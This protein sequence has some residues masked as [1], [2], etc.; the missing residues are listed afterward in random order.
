MRLEVIDKITTDIGRGYDGYISLCGFGEPTLHPYINEISEL[1]SAK[2]PDAHIILITDADDDITI[3]SLPY[4]KN[5]EIYCSM[6]EPFS[7]SKIDR[8]NKSPNRIVYRDIHNDNM[9]F[10]NNRAGNSIRQNEKMLPLK[11]PCYLPF[12]KTSID[13]NGDVLLCCGDWKREQVFG[14]VM[15]ENLYDIWNCEELNNIRKELLQCDRTGKICERCDADGTLCGENII[16]KW[17]CIY[18]YM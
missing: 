7:Q 4:I 10:F 11:Q 5:L 13:V 15:K 1:C 9:K 12:Y 3:V 6:Y 14:N 17:K 16:E 18:G 8:L 2:C